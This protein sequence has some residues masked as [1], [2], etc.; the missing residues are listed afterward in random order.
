MQGTTIW[1]TTG[2]CGCFW[3]SL[4]DPASSGPRNVGLGPAHRDRHRHTQ[5]NLR[6]PFP[7]AALELRF[8]RHT[9]GRALVPGA[10]LRN[11]ASGVGVAM[12]PERHSQQSR[13]W[14]RVSVKNERLAKNGPT[15]SQTARK[16]GPSTCVSQGRERQPQEPRFKR[17][18]WGTSRKSGVCCL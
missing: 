10:E 2:V 17:R 4:G 13:A 8:Q 12:E 1:R 3:A 7:M 16:D 9:L 14:S 18:T 6:G 11:A 5:G 15:L